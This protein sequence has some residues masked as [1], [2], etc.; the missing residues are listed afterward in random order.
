MHHRAP[1]Q[2]RAK[3]Q[4][5]SRDGQETIGRSHGGGDSAL[6]HLNQLPLASVLK[7]QN[8]ECVEK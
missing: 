2:R 5:N 3:G 6:R 1:P 4:G 7:S 8:L